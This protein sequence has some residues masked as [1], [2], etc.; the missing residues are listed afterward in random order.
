MVQCSF[1]EMA[2]EKQQR[3]ADLGDRQPAEQM[4]TLIMLKETHIIPIKTISL[5][6]SSFTCVS[7]GDWAG[8]GTAGGPVIG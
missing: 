4:E 3:E 5:P 2:R 7:P 1:V 6:D 8:W